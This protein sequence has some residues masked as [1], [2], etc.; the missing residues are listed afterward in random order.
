MFE[1]LCNG[2]MYK[3]KF[4]ELRQ[5]DK[6]LQDSEKNLGWCLQN[7]YMED[8]WALNWSFHW[9]TFLFQNLGSEQTLQFGQ[10]KSLKSVPDDPV[11]D[12]PSL[13]VTV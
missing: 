2:F 3:V 12:L 8:H 4:V 11:R 9:I 7:V 6:S 10:G 1:I 5:A 13:K